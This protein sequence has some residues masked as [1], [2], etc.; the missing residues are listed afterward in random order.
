MNRKSFIKTALVAGGTGS[1]VSALAQPALKNNMQ[2]QHP[3]EFYELRVYSLKDQTQQKLVEDYFRQAAIPALNKLGSKNI[4]V[5]SEMKPVDQTKIFVLIPFNS[6][7]AFLKVQD[8]LLKD[9]TYQKAGAAYLQAPATNPAYDRIESS[10]LQAFTS[11]PKLFVPEKKEHFFELRRY[12][13]A[14]ELT[15]KKKIEM[16]NQAGETAIFKRLNFNPVFFAETLIGEMR[17]N[18]TYMITFDNMED[19]DAKWKSFGSDPEWKRISSM[20]EYSDKK[21]VSRITSTF[22]VPAAY[23]QI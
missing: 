17:P 22:L 13:S 21:N 19:H 7:D 4:G 1:V 18:L 3:T 14:S 10:F 16:F 23:S 15:G 9:A 12:E 20:P 2:K 6:M 11:T 5:F 8:N